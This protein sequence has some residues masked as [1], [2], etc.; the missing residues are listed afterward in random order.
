MA[1]EKIALINGRPTIW[2]DGA[3]ALVM[4]NPLFEDIEER[5]EGTGDE[6]VA[7]CTVMRK[8]QAPKTSTFSVSDAKQ[9]GL[10]DERPTVKRSQPHDRRASSMVRPTT[11]LG[12]NTATECSR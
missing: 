9:A 11:R 7:Y 10:W 1:M 2:G 3:L 6:R 5:I 4:T 12:S 8:G